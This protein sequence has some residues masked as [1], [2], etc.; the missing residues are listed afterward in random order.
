MN[1]GIDAHTHEFI[2]TGKVDSKFGVAQEA[3]VQMVRAIANNPNIN[4][5]G[6]HAHIGSQIFDFEPFVAEVKVLLGLAAIIFKLLGVVTEELDLGGGLGVPYL[7]G[8][9]EPDYDLFFRKIA[10]AINH[11]VKRLKLDSPKLIVEPGRSIV[12]QAGVTLYKIGVV[13][14]IKGIRNY[15]MVD[16]GMSD[17]P[18][19]ILYQAKYEAVVANK[20]KAHKKFKATVAGRFCESGDVLLRDVL[21]A[22]PDR[23]DLLAVFTTGAYNY[24]MASNYNRVGRPAMV[25]VENGRAGLIVKRETKEDLVRNDIRI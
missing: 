7:T 25:L 2:Q 20:A 21:L 8:E 9:K 4:Y 6:L 3:I 24:S 16:G 5:K 18:R 15:V 23:G 10:E 14:K 12:A 1:P 13:K 11:E 17:N 22:Q 19:P